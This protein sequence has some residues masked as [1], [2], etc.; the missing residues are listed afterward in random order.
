M[1]LNYKG[2]IKKIVLDIYTKTFG[3]ENLKKIAHF[4]NAKLYS[5]HPE[6]KMLF[7]ELN[8]LYRPGW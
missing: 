5:N 7:I 4:W 1:I 6:T 3:G 8:G 2:V